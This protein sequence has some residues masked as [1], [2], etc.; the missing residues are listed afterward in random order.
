MAESGGKRWPVR[1]RFWTCSIVIGSGSL[2]VVR[3]DDAVVVSNWHVTTADVYVSILR[4]V[5]VRGW[6]LQPLQIASELVR[7][8]ALNVPAADA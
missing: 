2:T 6:R 5:S 4:C 8:E 3:D 7:P 1:R